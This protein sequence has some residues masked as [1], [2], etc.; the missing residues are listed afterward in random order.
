MEEQNNTVDT[1]PEV[2]IYIDITH[3]GHLKKGTGTYSIVLEYITS[4]GLPVTKEYIEG[5]KNTTL[6]RTAIMA[7]IIALDHL[8]KQCDVT[9]FNNSKYVTR[10]VNESLWTQ[11]IST[12]L[13]AK[14]QPAK[15]MDLWQQLYE[16]TDIHKVIYSYAETNSYSAYMSNQIKKIKIDY[17]ED[18]N[19]V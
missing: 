16:L 5:L 3:T 18:T 8:I 1:K 11:W 4:D 9:V 17:K 2:N 19:N 6:N 13:N 14:G 15:N 10:A 12:G 7:C